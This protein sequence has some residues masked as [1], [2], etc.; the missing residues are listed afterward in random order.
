M[1]TVDL[2][3]EIH[4]YIDRADDRILQLIYGMIQADLSEGG[5][6]LSD[7]HKKVLD[8]RLSAHKSNPT[9][10]SSWEKTKAKISRQL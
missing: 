4:Q 2:R 7:E 8:E 3:E 10:G 6:E 9:S 1:T 5:Y